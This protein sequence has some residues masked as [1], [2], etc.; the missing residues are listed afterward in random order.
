ML[1]SESV[2]YFC[3]ACTVFSVAHMHAFNVCHLNIHIVLRVQI[4][5]DATRLNKMV[6]RP[7][8][9][10]IRR[11]VATRLYAHMV[12]EMHNSVKL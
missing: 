5:G 1:S 6:T 4:L 9:A 7:L 12:T 11:G 8:S 2:S 10:E 3:T